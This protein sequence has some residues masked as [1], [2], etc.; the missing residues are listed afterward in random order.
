MPSNTFSIVYDIALMRPGCALI[1][2]AFGCG[3][4]IA[5]QFP[6]ESWLLSP[7]ESLRVY[8]ITQKQLR[9]LVEKTKARLAEEQQSA[10]LGSEGEVAD[11]I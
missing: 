3:V 10:K 9:I 11:L 8:Q 1:Q 6:V 7:S 5:H 2:A 4:V